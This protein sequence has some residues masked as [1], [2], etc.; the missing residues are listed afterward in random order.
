MIVIE[1]ACLSDV[2]IKRKENQDYMFLDSDMGLY[3]VADGM[4]GH[5]AG[6]VAS[7][8]VV[9]TIRDYFKQSLNNDANAKL[10]HKDASLSKH[11][12]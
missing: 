2:G 7:R 4:G 10:I 1:S 12:N 6:E 5:R 3:I 8:L 9:E 11:A